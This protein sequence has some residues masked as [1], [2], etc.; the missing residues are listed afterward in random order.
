MATF[1]ANEADHY[2]GNGGTGF[3]SINQD[4][5]T[6][7]VRFLYN[8]VEDIEG[9]SVHK[10]DVEGS[11]SERYVNCLRDYND[12]LDVCPFC[13]AKMRTAARLFI[14]LYNIDDDQVQ[15]WDRGK[16]MFSRMTTLCSKYASEGKSLVNS[17]FEIVREGKPGETS[18]T[19]DIYFMER[20]NTTL[21]ELPEAKPVL[22]PD[23]SLVLEKTSEEMEYYLSHNHSFPGSSES[24]SNSSSEMP[25]RRRS[26][27]RRTPATMNRGEAF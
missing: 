7:R 1:K 9:L 5:G 23:K 11:K 18:T 4:K 21:E 17:I 22:G 20:D 10:V 25:I 3:F 27:E 19:Y 12:P 26:E 6:K 8:T 24:V 15:I 16:T 2:G 13:K 14:P